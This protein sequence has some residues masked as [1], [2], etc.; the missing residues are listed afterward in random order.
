M[1]ERYL[2]KQTQKEKF[3]VIIVRPSVVTPSLHDP[4]PGWTDNYYGPT[5]YFVVSGSNSFRF[6]QIEF[7]IDCHDLITC[8]FR[9]RSVAINDC[10]QGEDL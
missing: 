4:L 3:E 10:G 5:G 9:Q 8:K 6:V 1:A 2:A 7:R